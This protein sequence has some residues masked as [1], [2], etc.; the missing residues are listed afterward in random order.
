[1][2]YLDSHA[3]GAANALHRVA[4][5]IARFFKSIGRALLVSSNATQRLKLVEKLQAKTDAELAELGIPRDDIVRYVFIDI[6]HI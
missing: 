1:M 6:M 3:A 2:A 5:G 4:D